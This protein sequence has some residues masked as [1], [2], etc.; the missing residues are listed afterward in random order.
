MNVVGANVKKLCTELIQDLISPPILSS[1]GADKLPE[2]AI[3]C[4]CN[5]MD[6]GKPKQKG[7]DMVTKGSDPRAGHE[8]PSAKG[9]PFS[10]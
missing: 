3:H 6:V 10:V 8:A 1:E 4:K 7:V 9:L 5:C 2:C